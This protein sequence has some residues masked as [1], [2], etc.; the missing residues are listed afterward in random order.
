MM[1]RLEDETLNGETFMRVN[2]EASGELS[3]REILFR[4]LLGEPGPWFGERFDLPL[5]ST[6][7]FPTAAVLMTF[8]I[9][10]DELRPDKF[11]ITVDL[12][13]ERDWIAS[14]TETFEILEFDAP[15]VD[16]PALA[17]E[18]GSA[19]P[20]GVAGRDEVMG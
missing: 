18:R 2:M 13:V 3:D 16:A 7:P 4:V 12:S 20:S 15:E 10:V 19:V 17:G 14:R 11:E 9:S 8:W 6:P 5:P 1:T